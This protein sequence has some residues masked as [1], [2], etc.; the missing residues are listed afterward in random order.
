MIGRTLSHFRIIEKI[1]E[2]GMG[3]V[4]RAED[5]KLR[6]QVAL[7][8]LP[9][10]L[11]GNEE[12]RLRFLR[13]AR[14]AAAVTHS[15]IATIHEVDEVE[16][17]VFIAMELVE[18]KTLRALI[19]G[20]PMPIQSALRIATEM[21]EGLAK[22]HQAGVIHRD[23]KPDNVIVDSD[24]H[25]KILDFGLAKL[26]EVHAGA[27]TEELSKLQTIS[28]E[29][30]R[31][32]KIFGTAAYMS[33]EQAE[34]KP[35]D[36]R[37]DI[38]SFGTVLYEMLTGQRPFMGKSR[39]SMLIAI[40]RDPP[41]ALNLVRGEMP[42]DLERILFRCLEK[43]P[44]SRYASASE[45]SKSLA[46]CQLKLAASGVGL[47]AVLRRPRFAVAGLVLL[48]AAFAAGTW[49]FVHSSRAR[50]AR[51]VALPEIARLSENGEYSAALKLA[52]RSVRIIPDDPQLR[53]LLNAVS[54]PASIHTT[55]L[56]AS[57]Y[58]RVYRDIEGAWE[59]LGTSPLKD[60]LLPA[61]LLRFRFEKDGFE[62]SERSE[63]GSRELR[64]QLE[65]HGAGPE[66][67]VRVPAGP[68]RFGK[69]P[70]VQLEE[71]W[72]DRYEVTNE[73]YRQFVEAGG[74]LKREY[75]QHPFVVD[76]REI[77]WENAMARF[78]DS[79]RRPGPATW[80]LGSHP[81]GAADLPV[82]GVSWY[83]AAAYAAFAGKSLPTVFHWYNAADMSVF[84]DILAVSNIDNRH[85]GPAPAGRS[86]GLGPYGTYDMAGN[87]REWAANAVG[88]RRYV[89]GGAWN[90]P[91]YKFRDS[92]AASPFDRSP[93]NGLRCI[94]TANP[95]E[96]VLTRAIKEPV[97]DFNLEAPVDDATFE[98]YRG[99]Y[100]YD[101]SDLDARI[102]VVDDSHPHWRREILSFRAAYGDHDERVI[103]H[104]FLPGTARPRF[105]PW[106]SSHILGRENLPLAGN[107]RRVPSSRSF[108]ARAG[109][110]CTL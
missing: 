60:I 56:G 39:T 100:A 38:F 21:A 10:E 49:F 32:G 54:V 90:D 62:P 96:P 33:P 87:V 76:E 25:A 28:G 73:A 13:E 103:A 43:N 4:Y 65:P 31:E 59:D 16:G 84:S 88:D 81:E 61:G 37:S 46:A 23:L 41:P 63:F 102:D 109:P 106:S 42:H 17:V 51:T 47:R 89:L 8:V 101:P 94:Q 83:E 7:K 107:W 95:L 55:P 70:Q 18:G 74:Y 92:D 11:V 53:F 78:R 44:E 29:L 99:L 6:R 35:V 97:Y 104:L 57:I 2:G 75:W 110:S 105:K 5:T 20:K 80:E 58:M 66:G 45:L 26:L 27:G 79:T 64:F 93:K 40:V 22:A 77:S 14:A 9:P 71:F 82:T 48:V 12:R 34:G 85:D 86:T 52:R 19:A 30:T 1:G 68:S 98:I 67:M 24:G 91:P 3:V 69:S 50:W 36:V 108:H 72:I 15:N